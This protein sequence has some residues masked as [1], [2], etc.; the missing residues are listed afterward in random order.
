MTIT[1]KLQEEEKL[2]FHVVTNSLYFP[3]I[4]MWFLLNP[5]GKATV[6]MQSLD[7]LEWLSK[8][9]TFKKYNSSDP[10]YTSELNYLRFYLPEIFPALNRIVLFDHDVV[11]QQDLSGLWNANMNGKVIAA[12]GTC[13]EGETSFHRMDMFINFSDPFIAKKFDVN[14]CTW[15]FGMNLFDLQ[16]WRRH[17]LTAV[18][19]KY[20]Q[21]VWVKKCLCFVVGF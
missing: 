4:S 7:N 1:F 12:V 3:A 14:A 16:Q 18:Y 5:P 6:H 9:N 21:M 17:N 13:R 10:R 2:V 19:H 20:L 15:A 11:V 8:Y